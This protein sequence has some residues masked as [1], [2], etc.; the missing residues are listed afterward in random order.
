MGSVPLLASAA[1]SNALDSHPRAFPEQGDRGRGGAAE[2][3]SMRARVRPDPGDRAALRLFPSTGLQS[4]PCGS[5]TPKCAR[6]PEPADSGTRLAEGDF[7]DPQ[8]RVHLP[9]ASPIVRHSDSLLTVSRPP[10]RVPAV[11][12]HVTCTTTAPQRPVSAASF[13][14]VQCLT[15]PK[16][17]L[18][19]A[20]FCSRPATPLRQ[21]PCTSCPCRIGQAFRSLASSGRTLRRKP[22]NIKRGLPLPRSLG[23]RAYALC[24]NVSN[25][26]Q[27]SSVGN[28]ARNMVIAC[29]KPLLQRASAAARAESF[30]SG[31]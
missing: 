24:T 26:V 31:L 20:H 30:S 7:G 4:R 19:L 1:Y 21:R 18:I 22:P 6:T 13:A 5:R 27:S 8:Q 28:F 25:P 11:F 12:R 17:S 2:A 23:S 10:R 29:T 9:C 16:R 3:V 15:R 14:W